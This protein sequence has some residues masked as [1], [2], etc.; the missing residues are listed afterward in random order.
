VLERLVGYVL[1]GVTKVIDQFADAVKDLRTNAC[2]A[3]S[4]VRQHLERRAWRRTDDEIERPQQTVSRATS[5]KEDDQKLRQQY[6]KTE[7]MVIRQ[8]VL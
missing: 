5:D 6:G 3:E 8:R 7:R 1:A 4:S 2:K